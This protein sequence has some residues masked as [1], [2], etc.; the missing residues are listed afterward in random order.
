VA[1]D[2]IVEPGGDKF[3]EI[4]DTHLLFHGDFKR[5]G[6]SLRISGDDGKTVFLIDYFKS[7]RLANLVAPDGGV[8]LGNVVEA[9][10]GPRAA[11]QHAQAGAP[12][13]GAQEIGR[14]ATVDGGA[15][16]VRNGVAVTLNVGD[17][18]LKGDVLQTQGATSAL[19]IIMADG[20]A[21]NM[22]ANARMVLD[23]FIYSPDSTSNKS[24][25]NLI[26]GSFT[27][28]AGAVAKTGDMKVSTPTATMG[29][30][31]TAVQVDIDLVGGTTKLSV[32]VEPNG[33]IGSFN[34]YSLSGTLLGTVSNAGVV[35]VITPTTQLGASLSE[36]NK[37][38]AE[39]QQA[40]VIVQQVVQTQAVGQ[41]ILAAQPIAPDGTTKQNDQKRSSIDVS[42]TKVV[43]A[44]E[45]TPDGPKV[46]DVKVV[47]TEKATKVEITNTYNGPLPTV[48][49]NPVA[50]QAFDEDT[51]WIFQIPDKTF[52]DGDTPS[53]TYKATLVDDSP[54]PSWLSFDPK[55]QAF[56]G[57]PPPNFNGTLEIKVSAS[58]GLNTATDTFILIIRPVNDLPEITS[59][60]VDH[61][62]GVTED[63]GPSTLQTAGTVSFKD[64]D[65]TD[66][67]S[68]TFVLKS[69]SA[70]NDL[71][72]FVEGEVP[73]SIS[74]IG[75]FALGPLTATYRRIH[76][77]RGRSGHRWVDLRH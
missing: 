12:V 68:A 31:G 42:A 53:L 39:L 67:H 34:V 36:V 76:A 35:A 71:P 30:R 5:V 72:G 48:L 58:D 64:V 74:E 6:D 51:L 22:Y 18:L 52:T 77:D 43:A 21:Y 73:T 55:T 7:D 37:S 33:N 17:A 65:L 41:A 16:A 50:D 3:V 27:F 63:A 28:I 19:G 56:A 45:E 75:Q 44:V 9:L 32:L 59:A 20:T 40:L 4:P 29:I 57:T 61:L 49:S 25:I 62:G 15:I 26:Q 14:V 11:G 23:E 1:V 46:V 10:A 13:G 38:A 47:T 24:L 8:L 66:T 60:P 70:D 69:S 54:L 2:A